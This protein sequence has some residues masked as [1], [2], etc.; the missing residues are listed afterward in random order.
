MLKMQLLKVINPILF[1]VFVTQVAMGLVM[2]F[3][4]NFINLR[5]AFLIH[6]YNGLLLIFLWLIHITLNWSWVKATYFL[7]KK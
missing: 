2:F 1:I 5:R 4:L 6:K 7:R 3:N